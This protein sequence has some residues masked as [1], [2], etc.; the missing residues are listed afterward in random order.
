MFFI[1][2]APLARP[3]ALLVP[4]LSTVSLS[5]SQCRHHKACYTGKQ[6]LDP[7]AVNAKHAA[8]KVFL[9]T[10]KATQSTTRAHFFKIKICTKKLLI[11][12]V[13]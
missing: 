12:G 6:R 11:Q 8:L 4:R 7:V 3:L 1:R 9:I 13:I 2:S 10:N 5:R